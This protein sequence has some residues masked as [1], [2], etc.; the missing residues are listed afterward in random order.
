[1]I[2]VGIGGKAH[3]GKDTVADILVRDYG[4][5]KMAFADRL[6]ELV[7]QHYGFEREELWTPMKTPEIRRILQGTGQLIKSLEGNEF[8]VREIQQKIVY[9]SMNKGW[10]GRVV[11]SDVRFPEEKAFIEQCSGITIRVDRPNA[12]EIEFNPGHPSEQI[13]QKFNYVL[14]N[15]KTMDVLTNNIYVLMANENIS[16]MEN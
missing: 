2:I 6:K 11:V 10:N 14:M 3:S 5:I 15:N 9:Q 1:M 16:R 8:W 7:R 4:F 12:E 13:P